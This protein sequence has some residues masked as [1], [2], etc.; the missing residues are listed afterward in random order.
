MALALQPV[1]SRLSAQTAISTLAAGSTGTAYVG[2]S[3]GDFRSLVWDF[4]TGSTAASFSLTGVTVDFGSVNGSPTGL[5]LAL[6]D[7]YTVVSNAGTLGNLVTTFSTPTVTGN[8]LFTFSGIGTLSASTT[9]YLQLTT[10]VL[11][12]T[13]L[14][15]INMADGTS[16][17]GLAGWGAD[18]SY[19]SQGGYINT[20][21]GSPRFS[22]QASA[23]PEP[24]SYAMLVGLGAVGVVAGR[25]RRPMV[26]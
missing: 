16:L 15:N 5:A 24:S 13:N 25:R 9:Y 10:D 20:Q 3:S 8:G 21:G 11:T 14:Y 18:F 4:S 7:D 22:V 12:G 2:S 26:A 17:T 23:V 1:G 19:I 6:Y